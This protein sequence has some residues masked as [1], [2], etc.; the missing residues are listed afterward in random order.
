MSVTIQWEKAKEPLLLLFR[1]GVNG[2]DEHFFF[3][4]SFLRGLFIADGMHTFCI[5]ISVLK[6]LGKKQICRY[7][8]KKC[9]GRE[10]LYEK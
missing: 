5:W 9:V 10:Q 6:P 2:K 1:V 3:F 8:R 4:L 7:R